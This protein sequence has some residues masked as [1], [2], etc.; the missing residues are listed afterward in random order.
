[1]HAKKFPNIKPYSNIWPF[2]DIYVSSLTLAMDIV[3]QLPDKG[4]CAYELHQMHTLNK[5]IWKALFFY[6]EFAAST[7]LNYLIETDKSKK[8][9]AVKRNPR[10]IHYIKTPALRI[11]HRSYYCW[12]T[13]KQINGPST[14]NN[15][16]VG[17]T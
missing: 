11:D 2:N 16:V 17:S 1:M 15:T 6:G 9:K 12:P 5:V 14:L 13:I 8:N 7:T 10:K 4:L 3:H